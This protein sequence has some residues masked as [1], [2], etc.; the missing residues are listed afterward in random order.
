M[1]NI[2]CGFPKNALESDNCYMHGTPDPSTYAKGRVSR[3]EGV[4]IAP[5]NMAQAQ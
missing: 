1:N 3:L 4:L 5:D 2:N